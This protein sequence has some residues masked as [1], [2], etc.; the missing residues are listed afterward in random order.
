FALGREVDCLAAVGAV[1]EQRVAAVS[2]LDNTAA[3]ARVPPERVIAGAHEGGIVGPVTIDELVAVTT[4]DRLD[5][6]TAQYRVVTF[7]ADDRSRLVDRPVRLV[8]PH[9]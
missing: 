5:R 9:E 3:V 6:R 4:V 1:E 8:D 7:P 2:A